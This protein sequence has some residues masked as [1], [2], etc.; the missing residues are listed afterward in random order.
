[1]KNVDLSLNIDNTAEMFFKPCVERVNEDP[2][3]NQ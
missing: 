3:T 1:M 2:N